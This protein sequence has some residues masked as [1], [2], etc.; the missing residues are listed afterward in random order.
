MYDRIWKCRD[1]RELPVGRMS[2][3]H[4]VHS[5]RLIRRTGWRREFL[6]RLVL[7]LEMRSQG[8]VEDPGDWY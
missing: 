7:E 4:I 1:G 5:I 8:L 6:D 2:S 3:R